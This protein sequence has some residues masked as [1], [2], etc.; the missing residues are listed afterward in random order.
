MIECRNITFRY[1]KDSEPALDDVSLKIVPG[2]NICI[3]GS[4]GSGK[5]TLARLLAGLIEADHGELTLNGRPISEDSGRASIG[6]LFQNPDNQMVA[7][8]VDKEVAFALEN[9]ATPLSEME[10]RVTE[11][12]G[13]FGVSHLSNR[14]TSE[15]SGGEKQRVALAAATVC[16]PSVL[17]LDEPDS[18]LDADGRKILREELRRIREASPDL[19][20]IRVTQFPTV[21]MGVSRLLVLHGG[22]VIADASPDEIFGDSELCRKASL[23]F[24]PDNHRSMKFPAVLTGRSPDD[25]G[26]PDKI[27]LQDVSFGYSASR[28]I[29][30]GLDL[31][32]RTGETVGLVGPTGSGKSSLGLL[33]CSLLRP[34]E[35]E[36][37]FFDRSGHLISQT[38]RPGWVA[39][40]L[41]L[42]ERQ[43]FLSTCAA[44]VAFGP[45]NLGYTP[46]EEEVSGYFDLVGLD[47]E[48]F[49]QRDPFSLSVGEKRR[50][51]F[52]AV[53][54][55]L[56]AFT[57][58][59]EPTASLDQEGVGRFIMLSRLLKQRGMGQVVISHDGDVVKA[60]A[61]RII[62][63]NGDGKGREITTSELFSMNEYAEMVSSRSD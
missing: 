7:M 36:T 52:A 11:T 9:Q 13:K 2:E 63:L 25:A 27:V 19:I 45:G 8:V 54:S 47:A 48:R 21:A 46:T 59:D 18:F 60:L 22:K 50:L 17:I 32:L 1:R 15:L 3:M 6:I 58:F 62:Y 44:E 4:N 28:P 20:E 53:L 35:G 37:K 14:L 12:L 5:S 30:T 23:R 16:R 24:D 33:L 10:T 39:G 34:F 26:S 38:G 31:E 43:F 41:Q 42:P 55:M 49:G 29:L 57:V 40:V 61:D 56:P 51:A